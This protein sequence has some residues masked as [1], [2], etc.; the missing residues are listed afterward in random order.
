MPKKTEA[1]LREASAE[2]L[3]PLS[4]AVRYVTYCGPA[5]AIVRHNGSTFGLHPGHCVF[6][7]GAFHAVALGALALRDAL[8]MPVL[9]ITFRPTVSAGGT[10][11]LGETPTGYVHGLVQVPGSLGSDAESGTVTIDDGLRSGT[12]AFRVNGQRVTGRWTCG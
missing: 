4:H 1:Q 8:P 10:F 9:G 6:E 7:A 11:T 3:G 12:F 2:L 5:R